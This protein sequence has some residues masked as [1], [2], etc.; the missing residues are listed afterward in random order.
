VNRPTVDDLKPQ[1][2]RFQ[3]SLRK[4]MLWMVVWGAYL[5]L[6]RWIGPDQ[7]FG[8]ILT[9][10]LMVIL[11]V[12]LKWG[13]SPKG[14]RVACHLTGFITVSWIAFLQLADQPDL[15]A[16]WLG[17]CSLLAVGWLVGY[18]VGFNA[19]LIADFFVNVVN[20]VDDSLRTRKQRERRQPT[21]SE[22]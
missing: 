14:R 19:F 17:R 3:F 10:W 6:A 16:G 7:P 1:R 2:R 15:R 11:F 18:L 13:Y 8:L 5:A 21:S 22:S 4:L 9:L 20:L 12:R